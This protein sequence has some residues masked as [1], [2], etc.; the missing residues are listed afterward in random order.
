MISLM[1]QNNSAAASPDFVSGWL[2]QPFLTHFSN[3]LSSTSKIVYFSVLKGVSAVLKMK[4]EC[5]VFTCGLC[6]TLLVFHLLMDRSVYPSQLSERTMLRSCLVSGLFGG[7]VSDE[8]CLK[9]M[10]TPC[11]LRI[12][13]SDT[14]VMHGITSLHI[15]LRV[16]LLFLIALVS[17]L[18]KTCFG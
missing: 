4:T 10:G 12:R 8:P 3:H 16:G 15:L 6:S 5:F 9:N 18:T 1:Q 14:P 7:Q 17:V 13:P 2:F 11:L